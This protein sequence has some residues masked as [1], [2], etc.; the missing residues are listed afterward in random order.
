M[1]VEIWLILTT[2]GGVIVNILH[3]R[4]VQTY[5]KIASYPYS[6]RTNS[7][8]NGEIHNEDN[9]CV[10]GT[11]I[12]FSFCSY[13]RESENCS[14]VNHLSFFLL[15]TRNSFLLIKGLSQSIWENTETVNLV[16]RSEK[17]NLLNS[18]VVERFWRIWGRTYWNSCRD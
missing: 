8:H 14:L 2:K 9:A 15:Q 13:H 1:H 10:Y 6:I 12:K 17:K 4:L 16:V 5:S 7:P 11:K 18:E 3:A